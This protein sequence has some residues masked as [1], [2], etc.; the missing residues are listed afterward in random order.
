MI[1]S[2]MSGP[3]PQA[4]RLLHAL[5]AGDPA[6]AAQLLPILY[7]ELR[8]LAARLMEDERANHTL[9]PTALVH[10]AFLRLTGGDGAAV[11]DRPHFLRLAARAMRN[12]LVD[13]ARARN[14]AKR[15]E[16]RRRV[17]LDES[18]AE[19]ADAERVLVIDDALGRLGEIDPELAQIV[20]LRF[21]AGLTAEESAAALGTSLRSVERGWRTAKAWLAS[22]M[23]ED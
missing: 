19:D 16:R 21:F 12:V 8:G 9:Q 13:H 10:E 2:T 4:T 14:A 6:A 15:G 3:D 5:R 11:D 22:A 1:P 7:E 20:E 18:L 23:A 17:T